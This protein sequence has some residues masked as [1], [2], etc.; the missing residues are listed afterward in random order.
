MKFF[1]WKNVR[2]SFRMVSV[3]FCIWG[4]IFGGTAMAVDKILYDDFSSQYLNANKWT[5]PLEQVLKVESGKL[6]SQIRGSSIW[7][8]CYFN[9]SLSINS[10]ET[11][12][13]IKDI[14]SSAISGWSSAAIWGNFYRSANGDVSVVV[15]IGTLPGT[16]KLNVWCFWHDGVNNGNIPISNDLS[17]NMSYDIKIQYDASANQFTVRVGDIQKNFQGPGRVGDPNSKMMTLATGTG[18]SDSSIGYVSAT[19][20]NVYVN[21]TLYDDFNTAP[22]DS[23]KW[24]TAEIVRKIDSGKL[25]LSIHNPGYMPKNTNTINLTENQA[26]YV[27]AAVT[28]KSGTVLSTGTK[29][30]ARIA[31]NV[32]NDTYGPG[33]GKDYNGWEGNIWAMVGLNV[34]PDNTMTALYYAERADDANYS[35]STVLNTGTFTTKVQF[36]TPVTLG[37]Y[38]DPL[39]KQ[40]IFYCNDEKFIVNITNS[41]Y[42]AKDPTRALQ[43]RVNST[44]NP[45]YILVDIDNVY[46]G[47]DLSVT[48]TNRD[49]TRYAG[50]TTFDVANLGE[51]SL[52]WTAKVISG[53]SWLRITS[54]ASGTNSGTITCA[55]DPNLAF[56]KRTGTIRVTAT[57]VI[58]K[59]RDV[60]VT[61]AGKA[62]PFK[63]NIWGVW[64]NGVYVWKQSTNTWTLIPSTAGIKMIAAGD[65]DGDGVDDLIGTWSSSGLWVLYS[66]TGKWSQLS[67][68]L[69]TWITAGDLNNDGK[70]DVVGSWAGDAIYYRNSANGGWVKVGT[71]AIQM[72]VGD[73]SGNGRDELLALWSTG[74]WVRSFAGAW[75]KLDSGIP[76]WLAAGDMTG[77]Y[78]SDMVGSYISGTWYRDSA[79][80]KWY[81]M[82]FAADQVTTGDING[83]GMDDLVGVW[84]C[85][86]YVRYGGTNVWQLIT[87]SKPSWIAT[88]KTATAAVSAVYSQAVEESAGNNSGQYETGPGGVDGRF[89]FMN[90][91]GPGGSE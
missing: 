26:M 28:V 3:L 29:G 23:T 32:Y 31:G 70:D 75:Q 52:P 30:A 25:N 58:T 19:F 16:T 50:T 66:S 7:N 59:T 48:P 57:G 17:I 2:L 53:D 69:P 12:I 4:M 36:D 18:T 13:T 14:F 27:E 10:V 71:P 21:G 5:M 15:N 35:T 74:V 44:A 90:G 46:I 87:T 43:S 81:S 80:T 42:A 47:N 86:L 62:G 34:N 8:C 51:E 49:V 40:G 1:E 63:S 56:A 91:I 38:F 6:I 82:S 79:T 54:G 39:K 20:E 11:N 37:L 68:I 76:K 61:Q 24:S 67:K 33:S 77:D 73:I 9:N 89:V 60:T 22:L 84:P 55:Y 45:G 41:I 83:D 88:G 64:P 78:R 65:V 85:G 72:A